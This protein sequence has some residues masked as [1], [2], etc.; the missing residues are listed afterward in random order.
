MNISEFIGGYK[1]HPVLFIG[2]G[3]SLRYL[4]GA[5]TWDGLL[6]KIASNVNPNP[7]YYLDLKASCMDNHQKIDFTKIATYLE[8]AFNENIKNSQDPELIKIN[9]EYYENMMKGVKVSQFKLYVSKLLQQY[10]L[11]DNVEAE[12]LEFIKMRKNVGSVITTNYDSFTESAFQFD[13][14]VGNDILLSNPYGS[15]YKIHGC[16]NEPSKIILT[17][18]DYLGF[19]QNYELIRAQL[20]SL[21]IHNPIIFLG[22]TITDEN[23]KKLL[24]TIFTYV[25]PN[26]AMADKIRSNFLLIEYEISSD[27]VE[28]LEYGITIDEGNIINIHRIKTDN[29]SAIYKGIANLALPISAMDIRKVQSVVRSIYE[30]DNDNGGINVK[31][32][33]N[34]AE[35][36]NK[37]MVIAIGSN[38]TI[39]Y[40]YQT[41]SE[42]MSNYF[43]IIEE[44]NSQLLELINKQKIKPAQWFPIFGF[45]LVCSSINTAEILK[46]QQKTKLC[47][48]FDNIRQNPRMA[49]VHNK[50]SDILNDNS[51]S[52]TNKT[53]AIL[54]NAIETNINQEDIKQHLLTLPSQSADYKKILCLYDY[55]KYESSWEALFL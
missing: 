6:R 30:G 22:Y 27:N 41:T 10:K 48:I 50:I 8:K 1:N 47:T 13:A 46:S 4:D 23:I 52:A 55:M 31:I 28:V 24:K 34:I 20:L 42:M 44:S 40:M 16:V 36:Q 9:D 54:F 43:R 3:I 51:I 19:D 45:S 14:L 11:K 2:A 33:E 37:D 32:T 53:N 49:K 25:D 12:V 29:F 5:Y 21:F 15:V 7:R 17:E 39:S 26:S 38:K 35:L 18:Q